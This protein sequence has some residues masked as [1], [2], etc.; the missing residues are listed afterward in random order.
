[1]GGAT[2][3]IAKSI[4]WAACA[5]MVSK[6]IPIARGGVGA[7]STGYSSIEAEPSGLI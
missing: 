3:P 7:Y 4:W 6:F 2:A 5:A 1:M